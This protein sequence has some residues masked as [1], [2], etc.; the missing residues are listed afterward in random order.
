[1]QTLILL[2][3][4]NFC[5]AESSL[6]LLAAE[7]GFRLNPDLES[8][9]N[10][11]SVAHNIAPEYLLAVAILETGLGTNVKTTKNKNG[12]QDHGIF[13]INDINRTFCKGLDIQDRKQN[14]MCAAKLIARIKPK[15]LKDLAKYHSKTI[16]HKEK[17]YL[18]LTKV[19]QKQADKFIVGSNN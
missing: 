6:S 15:N 13:Q 1:M 16:K 17:Y 18:K 3:V 7:N 19:F 12:T 8:N 10:S 2:S 5:L 9:I 11:A 4:L 14:A